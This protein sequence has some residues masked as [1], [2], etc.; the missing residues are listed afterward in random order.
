MSEIETPCLKICMLDAQGQYCMGC[1]RT[2]QEVGDWLI[3][4]PDERAAVMDQL[5]ARK[6]KLNS[7]K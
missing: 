3:M 6:E 2:R 4:S 1:Y 5:T 7:P